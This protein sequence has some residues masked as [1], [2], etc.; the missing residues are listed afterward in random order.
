MKWEG[1]TPI[2]APRKLGILAGT[3]EDGSLSIYTVPDPEDV[4]PP[5][6]DPALP[7]FGRYFFRCHHQKVINPAQ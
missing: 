4:K 3:F 1:A 7:V 6:H 5:N 2:D